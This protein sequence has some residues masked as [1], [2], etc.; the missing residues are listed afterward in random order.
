[1]AETSFQPNWFSKPG[2]TL[3]TLME[4][5]ELTS[6]HLAKKLGCSSAVVHGLLSGM[7][8]VDEGL[9]IALSKHVGGTPKFWQVRQEKYQIALSRAAEAI[10]EKTGADWL[11]RLPRADMAKYQWIKPPRARD[12]LVKA[13]LAY[14]SVSDPAEWE[15][16]YADFL[17]ITAF[18]TSQTFKS[19]V[20]ALSAWLRQGELEA[21]HLQCA[22]W[23]PKT[24]R[25][26]LE[27]IR[28]LTKAK[29]PEYFL[30]RIRRICADVGVAVVFVQA[31]SGCAA[32]GASR[33]IN[34]K[35]AMIIL[36]LHEP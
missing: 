22:R 18:R 13:Y 31:P 28:I 25:S 27:E 35:K 32:S 29:N 4:Q 15:A 23:N 3:L 17:K 34:P 21:T 19:K 9:A 7:V 2:D 1:M 26:R 5:Q 16:R 20:G 8:A 10:P 36:S 33:F 30:P 12:E 14:F 6:E 11:K 24:L